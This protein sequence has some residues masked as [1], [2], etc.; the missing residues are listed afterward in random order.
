M[1]K[2]PMTREEIDN[3][4]ARILDTALD[5]IITEGFNHLSVRKIASRLGVTATTI[6]NYYT[7]KNEI[8]LMIRV[9]GFE[10][11]YGLLT[12]HAAPYKDIE[13]K[14]KALVRAYIEFGLNH[15]SYYDIMFNLH[16]PKYLDYVG[17]EIEPLAYTEKQ[18]ALKCLSL[19]TE[20][21]GA[22]LPVKG[23]RKDH[24]ILYQV[25]KFWSDL[26][27]LVTLTNSRLFHEVLDDVDAFIQQRTSDMIENI[28]KIKAT[29]NDEQ[30]PHEINST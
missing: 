26:H 8:N 14:I 12:K 20:T 7:N 9:R 24:F 15:P 2:M 1:P 29:F 28:I 22:Y 19:F 11:L 4:R 6:Y 16:T 17:T 3:T 30:K 21:I 13:S 18:N 10:K 27:G 5:I 25:V 23:K